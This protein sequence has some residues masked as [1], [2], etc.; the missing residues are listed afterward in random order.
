LK[1]EWHA[2]TEPGISRFLEIVRAAPRPTELVV[3]G[4]V[5]RAP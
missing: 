5:A 1:A 4:P 3:T 2:A